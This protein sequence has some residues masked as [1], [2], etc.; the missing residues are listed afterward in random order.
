M[1]EL[2]VNRD[3]RK[4]WEFN[5][6]EW[7]EAYVFLRLLG[8]GRLYGASAELVKDE[9]TY[10]DIINIIRDEPD[11]CIIF[12]R[13]IIDEVAYVQSSMGDEKLKIITAP[14]MTEK[15][16][17]LYA[18]I[19][20][21][22]AG[23]RKV[24]VP[25]I[26]EYLEGLCFNSPKANLSK[27]AKEKYG[28]KTD[29]IIT[30]EDS[31][32]HVRTVGGFS[33]KSHLGSSPTLFNS[34][35]TSG[36]VYKVVGCDEDGMYRLNYKEDFLKIIKAIKEDYSLEYAGCRNE[37]FEQNI[38]VVD[39]RMDEILQNAML[40]NVGYIEGLNSTKIPE[41]CDAIS[42]LNPIGV[43]NPDIFYPAK[44]KALLFAS[45]AGMTASTEWN[46]RKKLAGGYIDVDR[47]GEMLYYRAISDDIFEN[48]LFQHTY[49]DRP[50]RGPNCTLAVE[51]AKARFD[52]N[53]VL[54]EEEIS[55]ILFKEEVNSQ[56][57]VEKKKR[58]KKEDFGYVYKNGE[59]FYIVINFKIRFR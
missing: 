27:R 59:E 25:E 30:T 56:G 54:T 14:E 4:V 8:D 16:T 28:D 7:T 42:K 10:I 23:K 41:M 17:F 29:I 1:A 57:E 43:R 18:Q 55:N 46:G 37:I 19:K 12:E 51:T 48:Y 9:Q 34:S 33:I 26:Q 31:F 22:S 2:E 20:R 11:K 49:I 50:D 47:N 32:D 44:M 24:M 15:A 45:F 53:R 6:G 35:T 13:F 52:E 39:S 5:K 38:R 21:V 3:N 40:M 36:F 58:N